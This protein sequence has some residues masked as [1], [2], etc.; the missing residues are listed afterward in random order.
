MHHH[1]AYGID[2]RS[3]V[4]L[5]GLRQAAAALGAFDLALPG[6]VPLGTGELVRRRDEQDNDDG[7]EVRRP[8]ADA[9]SLSFADGAAFL[10][11]AAAK[12]IGSAWRPPLSFDDALVYLTGPVLGAT[13]RLLRRSVLH[14]SALEVNGRALVL[15]GDAGAGK[16]TLTAALVERGCPL[17]TEDV[18]ALEVVPAA[19]GEAPQVLRGGTRV[20]LW[21]ES[22]RALFGR[23]DALPLLVPESRDWR[24]RF[25]DCSERMTTADALPIAAVVCLERA[26][27]VDRPE[28]T[29][30]AGNDRLLALLA[31]GYGARLV[32]PDDRAAELS[33]VSAVAAQVPLFRLRYPDRFTALDDAAAC[34]RELARRVRERAP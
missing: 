16:S 11:D 17:V 10:V 5:P 19:D 9:L 7:A 14:A 22:A 15:L 6:V 29:P 4:A 1:R 31:N 24:K 20:K 8:A 3:S 33:R 13:L 12:S 26:G 32:R 25:L 30:V 18:C 34:V 23:E 21:P 27:D 28:A 2:I